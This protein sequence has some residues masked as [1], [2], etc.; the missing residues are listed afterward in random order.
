MRKFKNMLN[1]RGRRGAGCTTGSAPTRTSLD[2]LPEA[3][4][5][6]C[7]DLDWKEYLDP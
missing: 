4:Q 7:L 5:G 3:V 2:L 6:P 1:S